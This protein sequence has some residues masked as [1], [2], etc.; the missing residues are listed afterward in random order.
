MDNLKVILIAAIIAGHAVGSYTSMELWAY[1]DVREATLSPVTEAVLL[2]VVMPFGVFMIPLLFLIAGLLTPPSLERKGTGVYVRD[3]LVRLGVPFAVFSL[4]VWPALLYALYRPLGNAPGSYLAE[5][6]GTSE[7]ALDTGYL[8]FVG[9]LLVFSLAY[10]AWVRLRHGRAEWGRQVDIGA[11]H[12][13]VLAAAVGVATFL[14]RLVF[15]FDSQKYVDLNLYQWPECVALFALGVATARSGWLTAV[16]ERLRRQ[17]RTATLVAAGGFAVFV[18]WGAVGGGLAQGVWMGGR[19]VEALIFAALE[20]ALAVFGSVWLLGVAQQRLDS[21]LRWAGPVVSRSAYGA[22]IVQ[23]LVLIGLA[24]ALRPLPLAAE[25]KALV[26]AC[27]GVMGS[28][29][30][31]WLLITRVP[32]MARML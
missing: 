23:G 15:P 7:E 6:V 1:A 32:G 30:L 27:G 19:H 11:R 5:L 25:V 20:S 21:P 29:G 13:L 14:V 26:V 31:A 4:V 8:W 12:L 3:R 9:D 17:S 18:A 22:F 28:F 2:A 24:V 16:P 10:A